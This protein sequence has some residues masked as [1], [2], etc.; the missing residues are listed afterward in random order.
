MEGENPEYVE[1]YIN[2][3]DMYRYHIWNQY[4]DYLTNCISKKIK[5]HQINIYILFA[6]FH[7]NSYTPLTKY[8]ELCISA[9]CE[10]DNLCLIL[11]CMLNST[12]LIKYCLDHNMKPTIRDLEYIFINYKNPESVLQTCN[13]F[14]ESIFIKAHRGNKTHFIVKERY[15]LNYFSGRIYDDNIMSVLFTD[16]AYD[17]IYEKGFNC[18]IDQKIIDNKKECFKLLYPFVSECTPELYDYFLYYKFDIDM[19]MNR[20]M[21]ADYVLYIFKKTNIEQPTIETYSKHNISDKYD[22][23][24]GCV[25]K[26]RFLLVPLFDYQ[27]KIINQAIKNNIQITDEH[28]MELIQ[29]NNMELLSNID[30]EKL[31]PITKRPSDKMCKEL[32]NMLYPWNIMKN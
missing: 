16:A 26:L 25:T 28:Y 17:E 8:L 31:H 10:I 32:F 14:V 29:N 13:R 23:Y 12:E 27:M 1:A 4:S 30:F 9:G 19:D 2:F 6:T 20:T 21:L 22:N 7:N 18:F 24:K 5:I 11:A 3:V 15:L